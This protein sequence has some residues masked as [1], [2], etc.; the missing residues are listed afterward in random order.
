MTRP[1]LNFPAKAPNTKHPT[2]KHRVAKILASSATLAGTLNKV[3][4]KVGVINIIV[5]IAADNIQVINAVKTTAGRCARKTTFKG[6][7]WRLNCCCM[8]LKTGVSCNHC[9]RNTAMIP[10]MPPNI[11]GARQPPPKICSGVKK[12]F[13]KTATMAPRKIPPVNPAVKT[14]QAKLT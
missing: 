12:V 10:K 8:A 13:T 11:K 6:S 7:S 4:S 2:V 9:R 5:T 3:C 1:A 14:A